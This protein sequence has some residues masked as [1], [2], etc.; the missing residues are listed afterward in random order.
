MWDLLGNNYVL[1]ATIRLRACVEYIGA[2]CANENNT[3]ATAEKD[4][5]VV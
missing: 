5:S 3:D 1:A 2:E 4:H